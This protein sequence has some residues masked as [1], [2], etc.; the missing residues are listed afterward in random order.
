MKDYLKYCITFI[1]HLLASLTN[2]S[3]S[4][5]D[6]F[7]YSSSETLKPAPSISLC[8]QRISLGLTR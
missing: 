6:G 3:L 5:N 1:Y 7:F 2:P 8:I 4:V